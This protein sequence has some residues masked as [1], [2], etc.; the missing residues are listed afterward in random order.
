LRRIARRLGNRL[1]RKALILLYHRVADPLSDPWALAVTPRRFS[2]HLDVLRQHARPIKLQQLSEALSNGNLPDRSV[3]V[4][5][6]DGYTDNLHSAKPLLE[7]RD[8]P[9][10]A[11]LIAGHAGDW[12]EFWWD[13]LDRLLLQPGTL[14]DTLRLS[15]K[16]DTYRWELGE[17][18]HYGEEASRRHRRWRA[19]DDAPTSRHRLYRSLWELLKPLTQREKRTVLDELL[20]WADAEPFVRTTDRPLSLE[21]VVALAQGGLIEV[22]AHTMTHPVLSALPEVLQREEIQRSKARLE[23]LV[24][25][26]VT[27]F[28]YP[29]GGNSDYTAETVDMVREAGFSCACSTFASV[30]RRSTDPF[31][32]PRVWVQDWDGDEFAKQLSRWIDG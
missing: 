7:R 31:Q 1:R 22:G 3:V 8:V 9:A 30:V 6:D 27:S 21:E 11:F 25:R 26:P 16:G 10:T 14:P 29:H 28:S 32:L 18:A 4:T 23:E 13:E 17:A 5:F 24:G 20:T 12:G 19:W 15:V 2:E